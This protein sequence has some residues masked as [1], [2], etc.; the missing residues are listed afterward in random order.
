MEDFGSARGGCGEV[1]VFKM[2]R[3]WLGLD[4]ESRKG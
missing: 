2:T 4:Q 1:W 3:Y